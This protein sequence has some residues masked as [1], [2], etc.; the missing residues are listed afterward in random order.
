[1]GTNSGQ[2]CTYCVV[3]YIY[4]PVKVTSEM[5]N[6]TTYIDKILLKVKCLQDKD[7]SYLSFSFNLRYYIWLLT[8]AKVLIAQ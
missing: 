7:Q 2:S 1:M 3:E 8:L 4:K 6:S 5:A